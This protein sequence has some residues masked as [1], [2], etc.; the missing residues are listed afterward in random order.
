MV[1]PSTKKFIYIVLAVYL[2]LSLLMFDP[3][4]FTGGDNAIYMILAESISQGR[5][6][7]DLY[8]PNELPH[9][10]YPFGFPLLLAPFVLFFGMNVV[11]LKFVVVL[12]GLAALY[13]MIKICE[14]LFKERIFILIASYVSIPIMINY[15]HW[16]LSEMPFVCFS[17]AAIYLLMKAHD[18]REYLYYVGFV[19]GIYAVFIRTAGI[20]LVLGIIIW[21]LLRKRYKQ[22]II[23]VCMFVVIFVPWQLRSAG[24]ERGGGYIEQLLAKDPYEMDLGR[25]GV[26]D[27]AKR[28]AR[29]FVYYTFTILPSA[30]LPT[31][32]ARFL[33]I[34][35]GLVLAAL[36]VIGF[37]TRIRRRTF[38]EIY[39]VISIVLL[40]AWPDVWSSDRFLLP[41]LPIFIIYMYHGVM[42]L[43]D[44]I[45]F[46]YLVEVFA[47]MIIVLNTVDIIPAVRQSLAVNM[48]YVNGDRYA[49]YTTDWRRL[50]EIVEWTKTHVPQGSVIMARKP[51]FVY[52]VGR[53]KS[54]IYP[55][56]AD[57]W[58][59][60]EVIERCDYIILDSCYWTTRQYLLPVL[61]DNPEEYT[62]IRKTEKPEFYLVKIGVDS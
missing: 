46:E 54:L 45:R 11:I 18:N 6:Y 61:M 51:E 25:I 16:I 12:S 28:L 40:L 5:G 9:T 35:T 32:K 14:S 37:A 1:H 2:L 56:T 22:F 57:H 15:N 29:N 50:F 3:K 17:L 49:G 47:G 13:F 55:F 52:L 21:L 27:L 42:W 44:K 62:I 59:V 33:E 48:A 10:Q 4:L 31:L 41:V 39:F 58:R 23:F 36:T 20:G 53:H 26:L 60:Q 38:L 8:L 34:A 7:R 30:L 19:C 43:K 24:V